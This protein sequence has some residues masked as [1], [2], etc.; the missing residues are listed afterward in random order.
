M[1][2][3]MSKAPINILNVCGGKCAPESARLTLSLSRLGRSR[4]FSHASPCSHIH[5]AKTWAMAA[6]FRSPGRWR[7]AFVCHFRRAIGS[8]IKCRPRAWAAPGHVSVVRVAFTVNLSLASVANC[9]PWKPSGRAKSQHPY[10]PVRLR[11]CPSYHRLR[12]AAGLLAHHGAIVHLEH[13]N[14]Y[15]VVGS[16]RA[17]GA[18]TPQ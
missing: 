9:S 18:R 8:F 6:W 15:F 14:C 16:G 5:S 12:C 10:K 4:S 2:G 7:T 17:Q 3:S 11:T 1:T 13:P